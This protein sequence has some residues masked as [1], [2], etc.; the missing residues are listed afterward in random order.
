M[1]GTPKEPLSTATIEFGRRVREL[2]TALGLSQ[3]GLAE[4]SGFHWTYISQVERGRANPTL[5]NI[6]QLAEGLGCDAGEL[7]AGLR[8]GELGST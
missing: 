6:M 7:V 2:R 1:A 4:V 8:R 3:E 5:H